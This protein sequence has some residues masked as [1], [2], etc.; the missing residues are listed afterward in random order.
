MNMGRKPAF[1]KQ[2]EI[3]EVIQQSI[4]SRGY[5]PSVR[6]IGEAVGLKSPSTVH[7][8]LNKLSQSGRIRRDPDKTR[9]IDVRN[10]DQHGEHKLISVPLVG[11]VTAG[12]P[13]LAVENVEDT[14][15]LPLDLVGTENVFML[16]VKGD[17]MILA[18]ILDGDFVVVKEQKTARDG[19]IVVALVDGDSAT[20]KR[21][22]KERDKVRLQPEN[23]ALSPIYSDDVSV[24]GKV[25]GVYRKM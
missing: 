23:E 17:S 18:G 7:A 1:A 21:F 9:A 16:R 5:P 12:Q 15:H 24:L 19:E 14:Y 6:E 4:R 20:V 10:S 25:V 2:Q 3:F 22:F 13:I 8:H 11:E